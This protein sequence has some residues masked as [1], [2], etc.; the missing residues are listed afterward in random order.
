MYTI[1]NVKFSL[2]NME[3]S[4]EY[5]MILNNTLYKERH[6]I[7]D[8]NKVKMRL[9]SIETV[10]FEILE[11][12]KKINIFLNITCKLSNDTEFIITGSNVDMEK[13]LIIFDVIYI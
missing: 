11:R 4:K 8:G 7:V 13:K 6:V 3:L 1:T 2:S 9:D 10:F 5:G 12:E